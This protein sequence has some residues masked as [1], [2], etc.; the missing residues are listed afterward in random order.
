MSQGNTHTHLTTELF[1]VISYNLLIAIA[2]MRPSFFGSIKYGYLACSNSGPFS[3]IAC[4]ADFPCTGSEILK[5]VEVRTVLCEKC[6]YWHVN[7]ICPSFYVCILMKWQASRC[8]T[9]MLRV[10]DRN[11]CHVKIGIAYFETKIKP[12]FTSFIL[13]IT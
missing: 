2:N 10:D 5:N 8:K 1:W 9:V 13:N 12:F 11:A 3:P 6:S 4:V 7:F